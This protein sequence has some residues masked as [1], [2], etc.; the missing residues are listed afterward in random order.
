MNET[1]LNESLTRLVADEPPYEVNVASS[2]RE[3]R[4][5]RRRRKLGVAL[6]SGSISIAVVAV[7]AL[8]VPALRPATV[9]ELG[10]GLS[11]PNELPSSTPPD[12]KP[13]LETAFEAAAKGAIMSGIRSASSR[14][15]KLEL[16]DNISPRSGRGWEGWHVTGTADDGQGKSRLGVSVQVGSQKYLKEQ[17]A[18]LDPSRPATQPGT[19]AAER[20]PGV[21]CT[22]TRQPDG[23]VLMVTRDASL[24]AELGRLTIGVALI[25]LKA[26]VTIAAYSGNYDAPPGNAL[27]PGRGNATR[28][29]RADPLYSTQVLTKLVRDAARDIQ[30]HLSGVAAGS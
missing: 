4:V 25:D 24:E 30:P 22:E 26:D 27:P 7:V 9:N 2:L 10:A 14:D 19:C 21:T 6:A 1:D 23:R 20:T 16:V 29:T 18:K 3:F 28:A 5:Q 12:A 11:A 17:M 8:A 15:W 13:K